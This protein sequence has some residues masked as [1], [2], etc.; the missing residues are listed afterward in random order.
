M[1]TIHGK[2]TFGGFGGRFVPET[3]Q[4]ALSE[5][6]RTYEDAKN[7][8]LFIHDQTNIYITPDQAEI[9]STALIAAARSSRAKKEEKC[10]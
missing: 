5:L 9:L 2:G 1:R 8:K 6:E 10:G 3:L 7:E 4:E